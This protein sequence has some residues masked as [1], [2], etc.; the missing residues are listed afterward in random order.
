MWYEGV[1][2][3]DSQAIGACRGQLY[4][5]ESGSSRRRL[6]TLFKRRRGVIPV[7]VRTIT[8]KPGWSEVGGEE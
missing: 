1:V 3:M 2:L 6:V 7:R 4:V 5:Y 8:A